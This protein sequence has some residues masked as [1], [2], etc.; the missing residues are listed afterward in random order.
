MLIILIISILCDFLSFQIDLIP[1]K[2]WTKKKKNQYNSIFFN[3][4][5]CKMWEH[6]EYKPIKCQPSKNRQAIMLHNPIYRWEFHSQLYQQITHNVMVKAA[7]FN[8]YKNL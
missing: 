2:S 1:Q 8:I 3:I 7:V 6:N 5:I 4:K